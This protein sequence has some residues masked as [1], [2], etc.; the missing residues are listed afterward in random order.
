MKELKLVRKSD[1]SLV[2]N[3]VDGVPRMSS[4]AIAE[5]RG[6]RAA[7]AIRAIERLLVHKPELAQHD[8]VL[9][10]YIDGNGRERPEYQCSEK[11]AL[12]VVMNLGGKG[13]TDDQCKI[14]DAFQAC[15][16]KLQAMHVPPPTQVQFLEGMLGVIK[17]ID[18]RTT[19]QDAR[20]VSAEGTL[21]QL[22]AELAEART[23]SKYTAIRASDLPTSFDVSATLAALGE[24]RQVLVPRHLF[25][26]AV[27]SDAWGNYGELSPKQLNTLAGVATKNAALVLESAS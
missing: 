11:G 24:K 6:K 7:E 18:A 15:R 16:D 25:W 20:L 8:F 22:Q 14:I 12:L 10:P 21:V 19:A 5:T 26:Y 4:R 23:A 3:E 13:A 27:L 9:R 2:I 1:L 17:D